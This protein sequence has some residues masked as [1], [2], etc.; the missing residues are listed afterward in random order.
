MPASPADLMISDGEAAVCAEKASRRV[1]PEDRYD[2]TV[3]VLAEIWE[4]DEYVLAL[5]PGRH[6][7]EAFESVGL[8]YLC[9]NGTFVGD[10]R[11]WVD[12]KCRRETV[13][14]IVR[15]P[16]RDDKSEPVIGARAAAGHCACL[17]PNRKSSSSGCAA[18]RLP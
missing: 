12:M 17:V 9:A 1:F 16:R 5:L 6:S 4:G 8:K 18:A 13:S 2:A 15:D 3:S 11:A 7:H 14:L 10:W